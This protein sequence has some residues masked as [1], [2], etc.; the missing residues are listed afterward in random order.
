[1][2][3]H[4]LIYSLVQ[5][6]FLV[7]YVNVWQSTLSQTVVALVGMMCSDFICLFWLR[8]KFYA[9]GGL[10][11]LLI[12]LMPILPHGYLLLILLWSLY[13]DPLL[14]CKSCHNGVYN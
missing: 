6:E 1:L 5:T 14:F 12:H 3:N 7:A 8:Y 4:L 2:L 11:N 10:L 9:C 13:D